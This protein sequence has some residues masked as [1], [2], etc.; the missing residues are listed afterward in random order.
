MHRLTALLLGGA[1]LVGLAAP[2]AACRP[3]ESDRA[4][5]RIVG[6]HQ[7]GRWAGRGDTHSS[8]FTS[9]TGEF[10]LHWE[11]ANE[12][13]PGEGTLRVQFRSGDSGRV[14]M[15]PVDHRGTGR[16]TVQVADAVRWY[17]LAIESANVDWAIVVEEPVIGRTAPRTGP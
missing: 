13:A 14:I 12:T 17:Y 4:T 6:W 1:A 11:A 15:Q 8:T 7:V 3:P 2:S 9:D 5:D 10:R 16:G